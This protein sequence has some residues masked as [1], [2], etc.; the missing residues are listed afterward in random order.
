VVGL[1]GET[2]SEKEGYVSIDSEKFDEPYVNPDRRDFQAY[3][4]RKI[5]SD[6][7][8]VMGDNRQSSCDSR[9]RDGPSVEDRRQGHQD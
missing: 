2:W 1:T 9:R 5:A 3:P 6:N 8:L 7:Y 4:A